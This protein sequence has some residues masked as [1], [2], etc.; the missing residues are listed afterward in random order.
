M[1]VPVLWSWVWCC[2]KMVS[3]KKWTFSSRIFHTTNHDRAIW[4]VSTTTITAIQLY[5][6]THTPFRGG[7]RRRHVAVESR[8]Q[9]AVISE[10]AR[11][12]VQS[13]TDGR[14]QFPVPRVLSS[15]IVNWSMGFIH[16]CL[17]ITS[18]AFTSLIKTLQT[19]TPKRVPFHHDC[20]VF[21]YSGY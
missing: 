14:R 13:P 9:N 18:G 3:N 15:F 4:R 17:C 6:Q 7:C 19:P 1:V 5:T 11:I 12:V 20:L 16:E 8:P 2:A 10:G 21:Y